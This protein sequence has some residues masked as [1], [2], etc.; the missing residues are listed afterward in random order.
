MI[1]STCS[2]CASSRIVWLPL[3]RLAARVA[4]GARAHVMELQT[5]FGS[6][7]AEAW[8]CKDCDGFGAVQFGSFASG[9]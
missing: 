5:F 8:L 2:E 4:P 7:G 9:F 6:A 1:R 3:S